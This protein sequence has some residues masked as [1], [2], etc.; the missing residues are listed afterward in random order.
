MNTNN[1][2]N[3]ENLIKECES[4]QK[5]SLIEQSKS[6]EMQNHPKFQKPKEKNRLSK[7]SKL[8]LKNVLMVVGFI[9]Y[10]SFG[11]LVMI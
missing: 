10:S 2:K 8:I 6:K 7:T 11:A 9:F 5:N 4:N 3:L 1:K